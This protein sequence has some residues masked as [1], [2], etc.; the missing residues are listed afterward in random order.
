MRKI[1]LI[2]L[3]CAISLVMMADG[4]NY[5]GG[6]AGIASTI[7]HINGDYSEGTAIYLVVGKNDAG[8][9]GVMCILLG[10]YDIH[11]FRENQ[12]FVVMEFDGMERQRWEIQPVPYQNRNY[13]AFILNYASDLIAKLREC[14]IFTITL[15]LLNV[16]THTFYFYTDGYPLDW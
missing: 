7:E 13:C 2:L 3:M 14:E 4:W 6:N 15:P 16:G 11:D 12:Q 5:S 1:F 8:V 9:D 10:K